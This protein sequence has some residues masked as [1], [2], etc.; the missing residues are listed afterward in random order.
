MKIGLMRRTLHFERP[1]STRDDYGSPQKTWADV[2]TV[3]ASVDAI[4][5]REYFASDRDLA[6]LLWRIVIRE[7]PGEQ[8]EPDWRATDIDSGE[9]FDVRAVLPSHDRDQLT[10]AASSGSTEP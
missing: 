9:V 3:S 5:G 10:L 4:S 2:A 7:I 8:V 6:T 1:T